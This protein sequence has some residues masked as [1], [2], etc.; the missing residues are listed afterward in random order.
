M[1]TINTNNKNP[2]IYMSDKI[3]ERTTPSANSTTVS[4]GYDLHSKVL[5][6]VYNSNS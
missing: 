5:I 3:S 4:M 1:E 6:Y 2:S